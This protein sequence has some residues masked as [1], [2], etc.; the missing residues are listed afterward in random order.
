MGKRDIEKQQFQL[1]DFIAASGIEKIRQVS[2]LSIAGPITQSYHGGSQSSRF[3]RP[4]S[5]K[6]LLFSRALQSWLFP[7]S[8]LPASIISAMLSSNT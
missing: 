4:E 5:K 8:M 3:I 6:E 2:N 1:P 7:Q